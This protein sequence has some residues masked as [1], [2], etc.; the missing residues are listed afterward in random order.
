MHCWPGPEP[1]TEGTPDRPAYRARRP[2]VEP[3]G[4][5]PT[6]HVLL[7]ETDTAW[8]PAHPGALC[9]RLVRN[10]PFQGRACGA[11][12][13][14]EMRRAARARPPW[15]AYCAHHAQGA[16]GRV[17]LDGD[18]YHAVE[19]PTLQMLDEELQPR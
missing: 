6:C 7:L 11:P 2:A 3:R 13:A 4:R 15:W 5:H 8:R 10:P 19:M 1:M 17:L 12:A 16:F 9:R 18:I 14:M